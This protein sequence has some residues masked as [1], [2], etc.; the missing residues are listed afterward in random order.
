MKHIDVEILNPQAVRDAAQLGCLAARITQH[1][2]NIEDMGD[3]LAMYRKPLNYTML[4]NLTNL[5]HPTLQ[6]F[7][8]I[9]IAVVGASRRF[10]AQITRHQNEVKF[11]SASLQYSDMSGCARFVIPYNLLDK[12]FERDEY[13]M[14]CEKAASKYDYLV[15]QGIDNDTCGYVM[16]QGM[17]NVLLISATPY[18]WKHMIGQRTCRRNTDETRIVMLKCWQALYEQSHILFS[19]NTTGPFCQRDKCLEGKMSCGNPLPNYITPEDILKEDYP[20]L[21]KEEVQ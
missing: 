1:G 16:P 14:Q 18:Q 15:R 6:K 20:L 5:P 3:L 8:T 19:P 7:T 9:T 4:D 13:L 10:L 12:A 2:H 17:R 11:M 21:Y